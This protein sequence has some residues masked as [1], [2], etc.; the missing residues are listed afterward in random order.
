MPGASRSHC[1][2]LREEA[3]G[4]DLHSE[5]IAIWRKGG[6]S[7]GG[8]RDQLGQLGGYYSSP[9]KGY[10]WLRHGVVVMGKKSR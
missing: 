5:K 7:P 6:G 1:K 4:S 2:F 9:G 3:A 10:W 8:C